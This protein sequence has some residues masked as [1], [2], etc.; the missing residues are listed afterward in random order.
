[1]ADAHPAT[2]PKRES[3]AGSGPVTPQELINRLSN[4][5]PSKLAQPGPAD[6]AAGPDQS[7]PPAAEAAEQTRRQQA[8]SE[9][10]NNPERS[11]DDHLTRIGRGHQTHG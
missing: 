1:M 2:D 8:A 6:T 10:E 4:Y 3:N 11:R 9:C 5:D 7:G